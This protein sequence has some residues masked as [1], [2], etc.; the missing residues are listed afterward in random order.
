MTQN[1][2]IYSPVGTAGM[3]AT[4]NPTDIYTYISESDTLIPYGTVV[5]QGS[6]DN[7][8]TIPTSSLKSPVGVTTYRGDIEHVGG[9]KKNVVMNV[10]KKG[11]VYMI[12]EVDIAVNVPLYFRHVASGTPLANDGIGRVTG[13]TT[14]NHTAL[15]AISQST[16]KA[17]E[18]VL[19]LLNLP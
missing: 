5:V 15:G 3:V 12:A 17:G 11:P 9:Y 7:L 4:T 6:K 18:L 1:Y 8:A 13:T 19:V 16:A 2:T 10:L 14:A